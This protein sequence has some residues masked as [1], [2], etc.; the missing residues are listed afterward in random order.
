LV[1]DIRLAGVIALNDALEGLVKTDPRKCQVV[2][3]RYFGGL[4]VGRWRKY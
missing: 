4:S 2:E 1:S 3:L